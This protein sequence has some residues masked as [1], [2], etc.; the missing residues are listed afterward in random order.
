MNLNYW[1]A[2]KDT[3]T[4]VSKVSSF[5]NIFSLNSEAERSSLSSIWSRNLRMYYNAVINSDSTDSSLGYEGEDGE[6]INMHDPLDR[7][8]E[9]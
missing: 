1:A 9:T 5:L 6:L 4:V 7:D 2:E 3:D 8:W